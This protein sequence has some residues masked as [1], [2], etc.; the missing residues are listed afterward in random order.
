MTIVRHFGFLTLEQFLKIQDYTQRPCSKIE[1]LQYHG[2]G[3]TNG[4]E[5]WHRAKFGG[6]RS[7]RCRDITIF[8]FFDFQD[9]STL[10]DGGRRNLGFSKCGNFMGQKGQEGHR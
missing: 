4:R 6:V 10:Q 9:G 5:S 8:R 3:L 7:N 2:N 1:K